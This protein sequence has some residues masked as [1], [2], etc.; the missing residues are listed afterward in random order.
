M[1]AT[2]VQGTKAERQ[3]RT[4]AS[5]LGLL[6]AGLA[7]YGQAFDA[8]FVFD[9]PRPGEPLASTNRPL[10][11]AS[12][13]LNRAWSGAETW[14]FHLVNLGLHVGAALFLFGLARR[15]LARADRP[16]DGFA[17][18][19]ALLWLVHP[20][21]TQAVQY[22]AQRAEVLAGF[23]TLAT[24]YG[25][26]RGAEGAGWRGYGPALLALAAG[27][28]SKETAVVAPLL[29][30]LYERTFLAGSLRAA[31][32]RRRAFDA[33]LA[34]VAGASFAVFVA[35]GLFVPGASA[36]FG[37]REHGALEYLRT[38]PAVVLHYLR[39]VLWPS[40]L[41]LDYGWPVARGL[42]QWLPAALVV[43][44][45]VALTA[46]ALAR[47]TWLGFAGAWFFVTLLPSSSIV[48]IKDLAFEHRLYLA[49]V[50]PLALALAALVR[51]GGRAALPV[52]A[53]A[54]LSLAAATWRR[55]QD[56]RSA[57]ELWRTVTRAA[58]A[59]A[60]GHANLAFAALDA[61]HDEEAAAAFARALELDPGLALAHVGAGNVLLR[62]SPGERAA[63]ESAVER[64]RRALEL[65]P[66]A[67]AFFGLGNARLALGEPAA[68]ERA[69]RSALDLEPWSARA[70][71]GLGNALD[72][73]GRREE[74]AAA[75]RAALA[76]E[77]DLAD[78]H[79]N[80]A[81]ALDALGRADE[82]LVHYERALA[83]PP[84]GAHEH[85]NLARHRLTRADPEGALAAFRAAA[86]LAPTDPKPLEMIARLLAARAE[87]SPAE[88]AE[89]VRAAEEAERLT[90]S[91]R[92][93]L[94]EALGLARAAAGDTA[95]ARA[96][97]ALGLALVGDDPSWSERLRQRLAA[98][99]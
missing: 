74:A 86:R 80:L 18:L 53:L 61:Q 48:P 5:V 15:T 10:V 28:A 58:P 79:T 8:P 25:F 92:P 88:R 9:D 12:F 67:P 50:A 51:V 65:A 32:T 54:A 38:Q 41:C 85:L 13:A 98:L 2:A 84:E 23:F 46:R 4:A 94:A 17:F 22:V 36:G 89:A 55:T 11:A 52:A 3:L 26:V 7:C 19:L 20:L 64:Y 90:G 93:E 97:F 91:T 78:A 31:W 73:Q 42:A 47:N 21:Q 33:A 44:G 59:N 1:V 40:P 66:S 63:A 87:A 45:L 49:L 71:F 82:A 69:Y 72:A 39:L 68:A 6:L 37:L 70:H 24:L 83:L 62:R 60:R 56:Y 35:R 27:M 43:L 34:L 16:A 81:I 14:S 76:R 29:V 99:R 75:F 96:A 57:E 95:G 77:P 30:L